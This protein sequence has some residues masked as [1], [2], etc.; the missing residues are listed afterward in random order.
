MISDPYKVYTNKTQTHNS[1]YKGT[2]KYKL[3]HDYTYYKHTTTKTLTHMNA[4]RNHLQIN[5]HTNILYQTIDRQTLGMTNLRT[6]TRR[7]KM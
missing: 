3:S 2:H 5:I 7:N 6:S 1:T 4:H